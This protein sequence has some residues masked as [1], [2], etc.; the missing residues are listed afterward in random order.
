MH[1]NL[2]S[3]SRQFNRV[4]ILIWL[5]ILIG[6]LTL[7]LISFLLW[8]SGSIG[9]AIPAEATFQNGIFIF[10]VGFLF[11]LAFFKRTRLIPERIV[12]KAG[13]ERGKMLP[14]PLTGL[15]IEFGE[16]GALFGQALLLMRKYYLII[17]TLA[18]FAVLG[19]FILFIITL[20]FRTFAI[21]AV[22]GI[23]PLIINFPAISLIEKCRALV[24]TEK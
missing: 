21:F 19:G 3:I 10:V 13:K 6:T 22:A 9:K 14:A 5:A 16:P 23:Y 11:V 1:T 12:A 8:R 18:E 24:F 17:W 7:V 4:N 20:Q 2:I 15:M